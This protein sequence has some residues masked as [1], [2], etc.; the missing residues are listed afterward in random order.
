MKT[1]VNP[2]VIELGI[3]KTERTSS[4]GLKKS[5]SACDSFSSNPYG[6]GNYAPQNI[7]GLDGITGPVKTVP[8]VDMSDLINSLS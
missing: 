6:S 8:N 4:F 3:N 5:H 7:T 2:E 1:W